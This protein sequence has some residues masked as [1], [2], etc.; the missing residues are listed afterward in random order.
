MTDKATREL[1]S[2]PDS[3]DSNDNDHFIH[4]A[5]STSGATQDEDSIDLLD[6]SQDEAMESTPAH[7]CNPSSSQGI[8]TRKETAPS[9]VSILP[10]HCTTRMMHC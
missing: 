7:S 4:Q 1:M 6:T 9:M 2:S 3:T 5:R 8:Q 10:L